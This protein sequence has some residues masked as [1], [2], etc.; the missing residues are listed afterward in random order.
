MSC[1]MHSIDASPDGQD[2]GRRLIA[3]VSG[4]VALYSSTRV[5]LNCAMRFL[6]SFARQASTIMSAALLPLCATAADPAK[7]PATLPVERSLVIAGQ[8]FFPVAQRLKDGRIAVVFRGPG[9]HLGLDGRLDM[10]FSSD[11]GATW[12]KPSVVVDSP[13]DDRNPAFGQAAD[14]TLVV[15]F[16]R[17]ATYDEA[18]KYDPKL[19][20]PRN[21]WVT[22]S[23]DGGATWS[24]PAEIDVADIG[25][26]SPY[27]RMVTLPDGSMLMA[28][29]GLEVRPPGEKRTGDRNHSYVY[30][31]TDAG[32]SW[33]RLAEIG[34]GKIQLNET[35]LLR[36]SDGKILAA[37][38]ARATD[39]WLSESSDDARTWSPVQKLTP[40]NVHPSDL[41]ELKDGRVLLAVGNRAGPF[42][43][44]AM[45]SEAAGQFDWEE[46]FE[47]MNDAIKGDCGYPS[48]V[49]LADGR[50][51]TMYYAARTSGH[52]D[53]GE[54]G[55]ALA[56]GP[57]STNVTDE[58]NEK[59][60]LPGG[61]TRLAEVGST[62]A[63]YR[64]WYNAPRGQPGRLGRW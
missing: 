40:A 52:P 24:A 32:Q 19:E 21:T 48:S 6:P 56:A 53:A 41:C 51:A 2:V 62:D 16:F 50:V 49:V 35:A 37:I 30:R 45:V 27:G 11:D 60:V 23:S 46:R 15:A 12:T 47:L 39:T 31:S 17:T 3:Q 5:R 20:K 29:Y 4:A 64:N 8:G 33:T 7:A 34:D 61:L 13:V 58:P 63:S 54:V 14:G 18:G 42:G 38:R 55:R 1:Y 10:A 26:G 28:V 22:R 43:V 59:D 9:N 36:L 25:W 44:L 57:V